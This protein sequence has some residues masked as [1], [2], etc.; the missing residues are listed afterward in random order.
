MAED[1]KKLLDDLIKKWEEGSLLIKDTLVYCAAL[2]N[3]GY[4]AFCEKDYFISAKYYKESLI[5]NYRFQNKEQ[6]IKRTTMKNLS[7][8]LANEINNSCTDNIDLSD[9]T[10]DFY[11]KPYS[12]IP[13][14]FYVVWTFTKGVAL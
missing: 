4:I 7:I 1:G 5:H 13:F 6:N 10:Y 3:R 8:E 14:S 12:L 9:T 11:K 2:I